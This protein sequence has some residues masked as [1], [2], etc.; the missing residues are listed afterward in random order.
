[1]TVQPREP[2]DRATA[3]SPGAAR[4]RETSDMF[5]ATAGG[6]TSGF[7]GL[8]RQRPAPVSSPRPYGSWFDESVDAL[9]EAFP[10]SELV[11]ED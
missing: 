9:A 11:N 4:V 3:L 10:G 8:T 7:G 6:D 1:M 5:G 2:A